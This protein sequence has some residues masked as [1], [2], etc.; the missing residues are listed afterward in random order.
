[1]K[2]RSFIPVVLMLVVCLLIMTCLLYTS[3][4]QFHENE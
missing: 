2:K 3:M 4:E 1:M